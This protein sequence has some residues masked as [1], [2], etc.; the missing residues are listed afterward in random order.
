[1]ITLRKSESRGHFDL[2]WLDTHH[3]F[4]F[5]DYY[6]PH[7]M[8][9]R[10]LRV[11]NQDIVQSHKGFPPH[12]HANMEII[13]YVIRG[14]VTHKDSMDNKTVI[15]PNEIQRMSAGTGITHSE[16]NRSDNAL[17]LLQIWILPDQKNLTPSYEQIQFT[18]PHN[19]LLEH[20]LSIH[21]DVKIFTGCIDENQHLNYLIDKNRHVW[22]QLI[23]GQI[24]INHV[25]LEMGD[26]AAISNETK[27][28]IKAL[29]KSHFLLFD[30]G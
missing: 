16:Y 23:S 19:N 22:I 7:H 3:T 11:I 24:D 13:T 4:S 5:A 9:F 25:R 17:E 26:G 30:L 28:D 10:K 29:E 8:G 20:S 15:K 2:G 27:L 6:D 21:Q 1:M 12:Q 14:E 18:Q